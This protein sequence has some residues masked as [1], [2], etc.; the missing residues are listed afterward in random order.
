MLWALGWSQ[1]PAHTPPLLPMT[2]EP[3]AKQLVE[4]SQ[5]PLQE[6]LGWA[7]IQTLGSRK[8][9]PEASLDRPRGQNFAGS[10]CVLS[11][12]STSLSLCPW[13]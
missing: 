13:L 2:T 7:L 5:F 10:L 4:R 6:T 3:M 11:H 12:I 8:G 9:R 1:A